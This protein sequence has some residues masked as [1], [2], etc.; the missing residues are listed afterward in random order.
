M[1]GLL[2]F[3]GTVSNVRTVSDAKRDFYQ[4]HTRPI[5]SIYRRV[6]DELL[7]EM[8]LLSVNVD[9]QY[10]PIYALGIVTS[11]DRFMQGYEPASDLTSI[12]SALCQ[13]I[14]STP[15]QYRKDAD[16]VKSSTHGLDLEGFKQQFEQ[17]AD[18]SGG[19]WRELLKRIAQQERFKY[20]R[21]FAIG[22]YTLIEDIDSEILKDNDKRSELFDD[23]CSKLNFSSEKL[24]KDVEL[25]RSNLDKMAQAQAVMKDI[26]AA[27]RKKRAERSEERSE[28]GQEEASESNSEPSTPPEQPAGSSSEPG[29]E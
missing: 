6:V 7:V 5:N 14:S 18:V 19:G 4:H 3:P 10:D 16:W 20:N 29:S 28:A 12:F 27:E 1:K 22:L 17:L 25:Y 23:L 13:A 26:L 2:S 9:F 11:F 8:H 21:P 24:K 15:E